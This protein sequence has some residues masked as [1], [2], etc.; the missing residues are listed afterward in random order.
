MEYL[1]IVKELYSGIKNIHYEGAEVPLEDFFV[2]NHRTSFTIED[3]RS[4]RNHAIKMID[5]RLKSHAN[6][7]N[8]Q[9]RKLS[10][11]TR[12]EGLEETLEKDKLAEG[13]APPQRRRYWVRLNNT[14]WRVAA[15]CGKQ[16]AGC[17]APN[18]DHAEKL[19]ENSMKANVGI[20]SLYESNLSSTG[21]KKKKKQDAQ[22]SKKKK[23]KRGGK[24]QNKQQEPPEDEEE[25]LDEGPGLE[26]ENIEVL[27]TDQG[28]Y[29]FKLYTN[30]H[31]LDTTLAWLQFFKVLASSRMVP[32][33][34]VPNNFPTVKIF[35][36]LES[37][38]PSQISGSIITYKDSFFDEFGVTSYYDIAVEKIKQGDIVLDEESS[39]QIFISDNV[40]L[41]QGDGLKSSGSRSILIEST[42][43]DVTNV[44]D[45]EL[46]SMKTHQQKIRPQMDFSG[47]VLTST[48]RKV[49]QRL[50]DDQELFPFVYTVEAFVR[51]ISQYLSLFLEKGIRDVSLIS[52]GLDLESWNR[53]KQVKNVQAQLT[54]SIKSKIVALIAHTIHEELDQYH[55]DPQNLATFFYEHRS[56]FFEL[57][58]HWMVL[59]DSL[60]LDHNDREDQHPMTDEMIEQQRLDAAVAKR[61]LALARQLMA[62]V[63]TTV[64]YDIIPRQPQEQIIKW[65]F[66][67]EDR[68]W[69][70][71]GGRPGEETLS[72][73]I[74]FCRTYEEDP[75]Q[76]T[77]AQQQVRLSTQAQQFRQQEQNQT[78]PTAPAIDA[79]EHFT[80]TPSSTSQPSSSSEATVLEDEPE[81]LSAFKG[82][83]YGNVPWG[84]YVTIATVPN[85]DKE[86]PSYQEDLVQ[87]VS[88]VAKRAGG[89]GS[90]NKELVAYC[91]GDYIAADDFEVITAWVH[92]QYR[93]FGLALDLYKRT[94][95]RVFQ[96]GGRFVT[97]DV[98]LGTIDHL[99]RTAPAIKILHTFGLLQKIIVKRGDSHSSETEHGTEKFER[100]TISLKWLVMAFRL[101]DWWNYLK[102]MVSRILNPGKHVTYPWRQWY[103]SSA[104]FTD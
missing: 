92:P 16:I 67:N 49:K 8:L 83:H 62:E 55:Q 29:T 53:R 31:N 65:I 9:N 64:S 3:L 17:Y 69:R 45:K 43:M 75:N 10:L 104:E 22:K 2:E 18:G 97:F 98:L 35:N 42:G 4:R 24:R 40:D 74:N 70:E 88:G 7:I 58:S 91:I 13:L 38:V 72:T 77:Q 101:L 34:I 60:H 94:A 14:Y 39:R 68:V 89:S 25:D 37:F 103:V 87:T 84:G 54:E 90:S 52:V 76:L 36:Q 1:D 47:M 23:K 82:H 86:S 46:E 79:A 93:S 85:Q 80:A 11:L 20:F 41:H 32:A 61:A 12:E 26:I 99:T 5:K 59:E 28:L 21:G 6:R 71:R 73:F 66:G 50:N 96:S 100:L 33:I 30:G 57:R 19:L 51:F 44:S 15:C 56:Q 81:P 27:F 63:Q 102:N 48:L 78:A 95:Y